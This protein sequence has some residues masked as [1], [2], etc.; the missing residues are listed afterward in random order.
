MGG[1]VVYVHTDTIPE[2]VP[3]AGARVRDVEVL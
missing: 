1:A 2:W 3:L